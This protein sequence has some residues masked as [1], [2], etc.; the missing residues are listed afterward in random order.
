M[1]EL[2]TATVNGR[3]LELVIGDITQQTVDAIVNAANGSLA[4]GGGVDGAI[5]RAGGPAIMEETARRYPDGCPAGSAV[6]TSAGR[7]SAKYVIHAVGP[8]W[9]GGQRGEA[10][11]LASA[12]AKS[13]ELA[14]A[15]DCH[16]VVL[17]ALSTGAYRYP[18]NEAAE[19]AVRTAADFL[20]QLGEDR[21]LSIVRFV[22]F[23]PDVHAHFSHALHAI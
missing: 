21:P 9:S 18:L 15:H 22:L 12:Y 14:D 6:I 10:Q 4:G 5:H 13:L 3:S 2:V 7:L 16:S 23:S 17:P 1:S 11:L 8:V 20:R 19:V